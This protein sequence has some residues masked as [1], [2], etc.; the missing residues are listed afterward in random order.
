[1]GERVSIFIHA[2][3]G[4]FSVVGA[5]MS[6][7]RAISPAKAS[8]NDAASSGGSQSGI[9][10]NRSSAKMELVRVGVTPPHLLSAVK[11]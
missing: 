3:Y 1:M 5:T 7:S 2:D 6:H 4:V 9:E 8:R 10:L 11:I